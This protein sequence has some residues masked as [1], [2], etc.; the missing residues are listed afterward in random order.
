MET[1]QQQSRRM[2]TTAVKRSYKRYAPV[3]DRTFR[4]LLGQ[5]GRRRAA[6][7]ANQREGRV[8]ELG[9]GTGLTLPFYR[10][11]HDV[12]GVDISPEMLEKAQQ[13]VEE[14]GSTFI[15]ELRVMDIEALDYPDN[16][17]DTIVAA[18][19]M[20]VV[21][22][23]AQ[24][25][26]EVE[27]VTRPGGHVIFV[28]HFRHK[29]KGARAAIERGMSRFAAQLG[30]HPDFDMDE[31]LAQTNLEYLDREDNL[32]PLGLFTLLRLQKPE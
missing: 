21:P 19:V 23:I 16:T 27:R 30:W 31:M 7:M 29:E 15:R 28:N 1:L 10:P 18:Y 17:F 9:V 14:D 2:D 8:L 20:S 24:A 25:L 6:E 3:Y 5:Q 22:D 32:P 12:S 26:K 4:W 13:R 11:D